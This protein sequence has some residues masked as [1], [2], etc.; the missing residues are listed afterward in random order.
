MDA[1][2]YFRSFL[3]VGLA[4]MSASVMITFKSGGLP[5]SPQLVDRVAPHH[6]FFVLCWLKG[7]ENSSLSSS[8]FIFFPRVLSRRSLHMH[9]ISALILTF[10]LCLSLVF[11]AF[12]VPVD[13]AHPLDAHT[14]DIKLKVPPSTRSE[15]VSFDVNFVAASGKNVA[16][17][18]FTDGTDGSVEQEHI[19][20]RVKELVIAWQNTLHVAPHVEFENHARVTSEEVDVQF[21]LV[22]KSSGK[23]KYTGKAAWKSK[24]GSISEG[25]K[26]LFAR[27]ESGKVTSK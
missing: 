16:F 24:K 12:A 5:T 27:D 15:P 13:V 4:R 21:D 1:M 23:K 6:L 7:P 18:P 10:G 11:T 25:S 8:F 17:A 20:D 2:L 26:V 3:L 9:S 14:S 22:E 19:K